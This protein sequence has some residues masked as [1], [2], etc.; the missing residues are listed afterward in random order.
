MNSEVIYLIEQDMTFFSQL[1]VLSVDIVQDF[2]GF[3][4][5][6]DSDSEYVYSFKAITLLK[7]LAKCAMEITEFRVNLCDF[8]YTPQIFYQGDSKQDNNNSTLEL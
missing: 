6:S 2:F 3:N 8:D 5:D 7:T 4:L 1:R